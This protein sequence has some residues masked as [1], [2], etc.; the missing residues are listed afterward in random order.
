MPDAARPPRPNAAFLLIS[1]GRTVR[2]QV[3]A[4]LRPL[5]VSLRHVS[6]LGHLS[7]R[8]GLSYSELARRAGVTPQSMQATLNQLEALGAVE[9]RS[10]A[11]RGRTAE[12]HVT[13][14]GTELL[15]QGREV[16]D[17]AETRLFDG[18]PPDRRADFT[19]TLLSAL[20]ATLNRG[21]P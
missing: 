12:L 3:E 13:T 15:A 2:E 16:I 18:V 1:L 6:A 5:S 20:T 19:A 21:E 9:R 11:G 14:V 4:Q 10:D 17:D 8:P 7:H